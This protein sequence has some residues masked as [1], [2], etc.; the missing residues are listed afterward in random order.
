MEADRNSRVS[1]LPGVF[2]LEPRLDPKPWGGRR[3][4]DF[5]FVLP[6]ATPVG[7]ALLT[8]GEAVVRGGPAAGRRLAELMAADAAWMVGQRGIAATG[9]R[10]LFPLLVKLLDATENL[11]IQ[12][13][14]NDA[15]ARPHDQLGKTEAWH[16]LAAEPGGMLYL[17]LRQ[18]TTVEAFAA[19]CRQG[20]GAAAGC[21]RQIPAVPGTT[22]FI[23]AGTVHALGAG[24]VVYEVQQPSDV[25]YRLDDWGRRDTAGQPRALHLDDGL[26]VVDPASRPEPI[27]SVSLA[28]VGVRRRLLAACRY[29]AL[30]EIAT[31]AGAYDVAVGTEG[32]Q[33]VTCLRGAVAVTVGDDAVD[34]ATG[35]T[36]IVAAG[37]DGRLWGATPATVLRTWV[38][39]L[40][41]DVVAPARAAGASD[42]AITGLGGGGEDVRDALAS[43]TGR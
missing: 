43:E 40:A 10:P 16:V 28:D 27:A 19:A 22:V 4:A 15:A 23:P 29:F 33:V 20:A 11:S 18:D 9:G 6:A 13:H 12:V 21:L 8:A 34:L 5:G 24:V 32:P 2:L 38:P 14:P 39:R 26:A 25:T 7:E 35:E 1:D 30:E 17:G 41:S 37:A 31:D 3:L 42:D 36:A